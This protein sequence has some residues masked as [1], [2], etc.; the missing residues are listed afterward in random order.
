MNYDSNNHLVRFADL[1]Y[2]RAAF[3]DARTPGSSPKENYCIIGKGVSQDSRQP[4]HIQK[5]E[6]FH[7]GAAGQPPGVVN[8]LHTHFSAEIFMIFK[9]Q[10][11]IFWGTN[12]ESEAVLGPGDIISVPVN[13]FRGFEVIGND[14]GFLFTVL[15]GDTCGGGIISHPNVIL[16]GRR[17]GLFLRKDGTLADTEAGDPVPEDVELLPV[18]S[19][20]EVAA[21]NNYSLE[22]MMN[23]VLFWAKR[24]SRKNSFT[25]AGDFK[26]YHISGHPSHI[27]NF[28]IKSK[29]GVCIYSYSMTNG[30]KVPMHYR[31]EKQVLI[32]LF[33]DVLISF[34]DA[35]L[36][37]ITLGPGDVYDMP[38]NSIFSL[39]G[40]RAETYTYCVVN[41]D[42]VSPPE[43][44]L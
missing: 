41:G 42:N 28:N 5:T 11:R 32:N 24:D 2:A 1:K 38:T 30:G 34:Q 33:G 37:P 7:I 44:R 10:F 21:L 15:G 26:C 36:M 17:H 12:G 16:E 43:I 20:D 9:G 25:E 35:D 3:V 23:Y 4:V 27:D 19:R 6:G 18:M 8:S 22:E 29:D 31:K 39:T 40:L 13:C 14:N